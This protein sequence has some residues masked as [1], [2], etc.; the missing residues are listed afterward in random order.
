MAS[1]K[2]DATDEIDTEVL[3]A[4]EKEIKE[5]DKARQPIL[6]SSTSY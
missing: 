6:Q 4:L 3:S 1:A 5:F 2:V